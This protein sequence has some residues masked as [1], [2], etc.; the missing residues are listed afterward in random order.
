MQCVETNRASLHSLLVS[1][2][3]NGLI[4]K[5]FGS[6]WDALLSKTLKSPWGSL[7]ATLLS[8]PIRSGKIDRFLFRR[9][10]KTGPLWMKKMGVLQAA[11]LGEEFAGPGGGVVVCASWPGGAGCPGAWAVKWCVVGFPGI[12]MAALRNPLPL[13]HEEVT[14]KRGLH[15]VMVQIL[16]GES[17][18]FYDPHPAA[19]LQPLSLFSDVPKN[20]ST[21]QQVATTSSA[22]GKLK[23]RTNDN[24]L[25]R[26]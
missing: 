2:L 16:P 21:I 9:S 7:L 23:H 18:A 19:F 22:T 1:L 13:G 6:P 20:H 5:N 25:F 17:L 3:L 26:L 4:V 12:P 8:G 10:F 15:E 11:F 24:T 14:W